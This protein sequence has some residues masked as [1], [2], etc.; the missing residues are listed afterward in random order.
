MDFLVERLPVGRGERAERDGAWHPLFGG[1][2]MPRAA[3]AERS[4]AWVGMH[5]GQ[6][7]GEPSFLELVGTEVVGLLESDDL[8]AKEERGGG[9]RGGDGL[10]EG[11]RGGA[12]RRSLTGCCR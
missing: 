7:V 5:F 6:M 3:R 1:R 9:L 11:A 10:G 8:K 12:K 2:D 4:R